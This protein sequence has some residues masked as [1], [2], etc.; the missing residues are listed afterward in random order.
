[1]SGY[2]GFTAPSVSSRPRKKEV[3]SEYDAGG[4]LLAAINAVNKEFYE[5]GTPIGKITSGGKYRP[6]AKAGVDGD[7]VTVTV[8]QL[9][10][11]GAFCFEI[12]DSVQIINGATGAVRATKTLTDVDK[13]ADTLTWVGAVASVKDVDYA[14]IHNGAETAV[15]ILTENVAINRSVPAAY[16]EREGVWM[17]HGIA[18]DAICTARG[19]TSLV[20]ADLSNIFFE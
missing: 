5:G 15:G 9:E 3:D 4:T 10:S 11:G 12:G 16:I 1:M 8:L 19:V 7:Q 6:C 17:R 13:S 14:Q 18:H 20:K 2:V